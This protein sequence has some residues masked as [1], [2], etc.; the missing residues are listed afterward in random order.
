MPF[1][2]FHFLSMKPI[3]KKLGLAI[4]MFDKFLVL[5]KKNTGGFMKHN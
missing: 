3:T 2:V 4:T 5:S 1:T